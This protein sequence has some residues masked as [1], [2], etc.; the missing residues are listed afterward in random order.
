MNFLYWL[1]EAQDPHTYLK[2]KCIRFHPDSMTRLSPFDFHVLGY[3]ISHSNCSWDLDLSGANFDSTSVKM[4]L[5]SCT[6]ETSRTDSASGQ[7]SR[8]YANHNCCDKS[9]CSILELP[10]TILQGLKAIIVG[11]IIA[12]TSL[13]KLAKILETVGLPK[14][15]QLIFRHTFVGKGAVS[16]F[17]A[18]RTSSSTITRLYLS[19]FGIGDDAVEELRKLLATCRTLSCLEIH[20]TPF[21]SESLQLIFIGLAIS[22]SLTL[23]D[24]SLI[25][26]DQPAIEHLSAALGV[27]HTLR[28]LNISRCDIGS[29]GAHNLTEVLEKNQTLK[30]LLVQESEIGEGGAKAFAEMLEKNQSLKKLSLFDESIRFGGVFTLITALEHN[31]TLEMLFLHAKCNPPELAKNSRYSFVNFSIPLVQ[32]AVP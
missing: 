17:R 14:L 25:R 21:S 11:N 32:I 27:N 22:T 28:G 15:Q 9:L 20:G 19:A 29:D 24:L 7:I 4:I 16:V 10:H 8:L 3:C 12:S 26:F 30:V 23:L 1:H 2:V 31:D 6:A 18:L 5:N 13:D